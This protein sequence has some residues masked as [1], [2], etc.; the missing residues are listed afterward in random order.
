MSRIPR[1][2]RS[3][4]LPEPDAPMMDTNSP[5][6]D[7]KID[8]LQHMQGLPVVIGLVDILEFNQHFLIVY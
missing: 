8:A 6:L 7:P 1:M 3:V 4:D 5:P 2:F